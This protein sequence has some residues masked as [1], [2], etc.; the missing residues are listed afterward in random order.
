M[1]PSFH[2]HV[3]EEELLGQRRLSQLDREFFF[4]ILRQ[5]AIEMTDNQILEGVFDLLACPSLR[6]LCQP[7]ASARHIHAAFS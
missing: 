3:R 5:A 6:L 7:N 2:S 4:L 1:Q